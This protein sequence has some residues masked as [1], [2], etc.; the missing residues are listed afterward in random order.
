M[1][2]T[3]WKIW[4]QNTLAL[5]RPDGLDIRAGGPS[6][7]RTPARRKRITIRIQDVVPILARS[8][9]KHSWTKTL[10]KTIRNLCVATWT[11]CVK[12]SRN[13]DS[14]LEYSNPSKLSTVP[15]LN[16]PHV[17]VTPLPCEEACVNTEGAMRYC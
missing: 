3:C 4:Q 17:P 8:V 2:T 5:E 11:F 12:L 15:H 10:D 7:Q 13:W 6:S 16:G 14:L 9:L 1:S